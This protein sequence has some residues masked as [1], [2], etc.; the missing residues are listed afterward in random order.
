MFFSLLSSFI[1]EV[2]FIDYA[3]DFINIYP[4]KEDYIKKIVPFQYTVFK[5]YLEDNDYTITAFADMCEYNADFIFDTPEDIREGIVERYKAF[6]NMFYFKTNLDVELIDLNSD[7]RIDN[8]DK[9]HFGELEY[10]F[11][12]NEIE[13]KKNL[14]HVLKLESMI[15]SKLEL[16]PVRYTY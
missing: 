3:E 10:T 1:L 4:I 7:P 9:Y 8:I 16:K 12:I 13:Y 11:Y 2:F 5:N 14:S 6:K 15:E